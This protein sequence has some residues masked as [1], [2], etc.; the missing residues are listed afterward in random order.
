MLHAGDLI[1]EGTIKMAAEPAAKPAEAAG[2]D[3]GKASAANAG[4][5]AA[6]AAA[7]A[8]SV[9]PQ[10]GGA[11][12]QEPLRDANSPAEVRLVK[13]ACA[14]CTNSTSNCVADPRGDAEASNAFACL[15]VHRSASQR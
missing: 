8:V 2:A 7:P 6:D 12:A 13:L 5:A 10:E 4:E 1:C 9:A 11:V 15:I 14:Q 3:A